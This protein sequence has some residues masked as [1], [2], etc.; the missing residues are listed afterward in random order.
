MLPGA[1]PAYRKMKKYMRFLYEIPLGHKGERL[2]SV[3]CSTRGH[4]KNES[5]PSCWGNRGD[6]SLFVIASYPNHTLY[7]HWTEISDAAGARGAE[8]VALSI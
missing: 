8:R 2:V 6:A 4:S 3:E 1:S 5:S 7:T